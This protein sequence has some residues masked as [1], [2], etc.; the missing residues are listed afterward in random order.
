MS[1]RKG[2]EEFWIYVYY[3][4]IYILGSS[5]PDFM[6]GRCWAITN[7]AQLPS[8]CRWGITVAFFPHRC[9][10]LNPIETNLVKQT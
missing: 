8:L 9:H 4:Y 1:E 5:A 6:A 7:E 3:I 10:H 2:R